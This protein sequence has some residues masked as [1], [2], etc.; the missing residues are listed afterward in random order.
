MGEAVNNSADSKSELESKAPLSWR[1]CGGRWGGRSPGLPAWSVFWRWGGASSAFSSR[2]WVRS[3]TTIKASNSCFLCANLSSK[4]FALP[5]L[6]LMSNL[7][8]P[9]HWRPHFREEEPEAICRVIWPKVMWLT[10]LKAVV[11]IP[12]SA[13]CTQMASQILNRKPHRLYSMVPIVKAGFLKGT[14]KSVRSP[15]FSTVTDVSSLLGAARGLSH[16]AVHEVYYSLKSILGFVGWM[17]SV[18][19]KPPLPPWCGQRWHT[20][21]SEHLCSNKTLF[22]NTVAGQSGHRLLSPVTDQSW[23]KLL[24]K[25]LHQH[26]KWPVKG[27]SYFP[28]GIPG[29]P[30][31]GE[32]Q[33]SKALAIW[34]DGMGRKVKGRRDSRSSIQIT[35]GAPELHASQ[36]FTAAP[37]L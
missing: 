21:K 20:H 17:I 23:D 9:S 32:E 4:F 29:S 22:T 7:R 19:T 12:Y 13:S 34:G 15:E 25:V 36:C 31:A 26:R 37:Q 8:E 1:D 14:Y 35:S 24:K 3:A 16:M 33:Q 2:N 11:W 5:P 30:R 18:K 6:I 27:G 28:L 10:G